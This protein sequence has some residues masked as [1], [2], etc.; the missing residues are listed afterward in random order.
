MYNN[1]LSDEPSLDDLFQT[2]THQNIADKLYKINENSNNL[3]I[4]IEG[5]WGTGKS[6]ITN[7][8]S[9]KIKD[10][11]KSIFIFD[12][13]AHSGEEARYYFLY[14]LAKQLKEEKEK[15]KE[16][17]EEKEKEKIKETIEK[18]DN[19]I[20]DIENKKIVKNNV[21][22]EILDTAGKSFLL[23]AALIPIGVAFFIKSSFPNI[24]I[25]ID[26]I[27]WSFIIGLAIWLI[28]IAI[29]CLSI[30]NTFCRKNDKFSVFKNH[31]KKED[32]AFETRENV[33]L[34]FTEIY[35]DIILAQKVTLTIV[36]D[37]IDRI[38]QDEAK[39]I[40][41]MIQNIKKFGCNFIIPYDRQAF[42]TI[43]ETDKKDEIS[44]LDKCFPI[45]LHTPS[46]FTSN[47]NYAVELYIEQVFSEVWTKDKLD[48]LRDLIIN[49]VN[50][51]DLDLT[52]RKLK[53]LLVT[54]YLYTQFEE[55]FSLDVTVSYSFL[56]LN[57]SKEDIKKAIKEIYRNKISNENLVIKSSNLQIQE[58]RSKLNELSSLT[59]GLVENNGE[60]ILLTEIL[61]EIIHSNNIKDIERIFKSYQDKC[62]L[63]FI[64]AL[65]SET[66]FHKLVYVLCVILEEKIEILPIKNAIIDRIYQYLDNKN[67]SEA[68]CRNY[69][70]LLKFPEELKE[71]LGIIFK[72]AFSNI[73][74][75]N[76]RN[77]NILP[78]SYIQ[79]TSKKIGL[80]YHEILEKSDDRKLVFYFYSHF[81][82][83]SNHEKF[84]FFKEIELVRIFDWELINNDNLLIHEADVFYLFLT[85]VKNHTDL[86][87]KILEVCHKFRREEL[88]Y[89]WIYM[90]V[91]YVKHNE[92]YQKEITSIFLELNEYNFSENILNINP[93]FLGSEEYRN[94][95][96][97]WLICDKANFLILLL[98]DESI[99]IDYV[100][101]NIKQNLISD[102]IIF[103]EKR[104]FYNR[105]FEKN[106]SLKEIHQQNLDKEN[107]IKKLKHLQKKG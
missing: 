89:A 87:N 43:W 85:K 9:K 52:V 96:N 82:K 6:T 25:G 17:I 81:V 35:K 66:P 8:L 62:T 80:D 79:K 14:E 38:D 11:D 47:F 65:S 2:K 61:K 100:D 4:G 1:F 102:L 86:K 93:R 94:Y 59:L 39:N 64:R 7:I 19:I 104:D 34:E 26:N 97:E 27:D 95:E 107:I 28:P 92:H 71:V 49:L 13:W 105:L 31:E 36:I 10:N 57:Y 103:L 75:N 18:F 98:I 20:N 60:E 42:L 24:H 3:I 21:A 22:K 48:E 70:E 99:D 16:I 12:A 78:V 53:K 55:N 88:T 29:V 83:A 74:Y 15:I 58:N 77:I 69:E 84:S 45:I 73:I 30:L 23:S 90:Y 32:T 41:G 72:K 37:N 5:D 91:K 56:S 68:F 33:F 106:I 101:K 50:A 63:S 67:I 54:I 76:N 40:W 46:L 44:F 51:N